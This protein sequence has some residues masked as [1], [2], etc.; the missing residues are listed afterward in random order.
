MST[1]K[2]IGRT[3]DFKGKTLW[4]IVGNLRN[5]GV[6]RLVQRSMF[7]RY[8]EPS[9]MKIVK[10]EAVPNP[11]EVIQ[12]F[13]ILPAAINYSNFYHLTFECFIS[14]QGDRKCKVT[15]E[16][17]FRGRTHPKLIEIYSTSYKADY[18]LVPK[19]D[20]QK[21]IN[22]SVATPAE[23]ILPQTMEFPPL[24]REFVERETGQSN[25]QLAVKIKANREKLA[26]VAL[27]GEKP[28]VTLSM[29]LGKPISPKLYKGISLESR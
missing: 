10:V 3:T 28:T 23:R 21:I 13:I 26:R 6:G 22:Q 12:K 16:K 2:L 18:V 11:T 20:E 8:P 5:H 25:P 1:I 19:D 24:L 9:F 27:D 7:Q 4:E 14:F 29:G 15:V 17:T